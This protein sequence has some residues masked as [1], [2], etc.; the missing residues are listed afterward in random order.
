MSLIKSNLTSY[1]AMI[2]DL[3]E[4]IGSDASKELLYGIE[5]MKF[6][7]IL[8]LKHNLKDMLMLMISQR[9]VH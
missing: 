5:R 3:S 9:P 1:S 7:E 2:D 6:D 8:Q 4:Y